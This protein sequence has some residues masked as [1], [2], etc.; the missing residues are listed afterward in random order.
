MKLNP[1]KKNTILRAELSGRTDKGMVRDINQDAFVV[2]KGKSVPRWA[3]AVAG[4]FDGVG[5]LPHGEESSARAVRYLQ[6]A[7]IL[8]DLRR[9]N[10]RNPERMIK[11][12]LIE[13]HE[14]IVADGMVY[15]NLE[16][17][18]TTATLAIVERSRPVVW[19]GSVGDS[20]AFRLG[21]GKLAAKKLQ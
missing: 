12:L 19:I 17:M 10:D 2:L 15:T 8:P 9:G 21:N 20:P 1:L 14:K 4:V 5:G 11:Q 7:L 18:A 3:V 16:G 13:L 6:E